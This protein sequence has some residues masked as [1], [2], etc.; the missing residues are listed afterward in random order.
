MDR[1]PLFCIYSPLPPLRGQP[2]VEYNPRFQPIE[3]LAVLCR[4]GRLL[5]SNP[6]LQVYSLVSLQMS[7][8]CSLR[9]IICICL[10]AFWG[11]Q[12]VA[13][14][15]VLFYFLVIFLSPMPPNLFMFITL[16]SQLSSLYPSH[17]LAAFLTSTCP[18]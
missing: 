2:K 5:D 17:F 6:G 15:T 10:E 4:L 14:P 12:H 9:T 16:Y 18:H 13:F 8:H 1:R 3:G 7:H 11:R